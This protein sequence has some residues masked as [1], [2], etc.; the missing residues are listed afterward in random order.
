MVFVVLLDAWISLQRLSL[1]SIP[2]LTFLTSHPLERT[3]VHPGQPVPGETRRDPLESRRL[4]SPL[5]SHQIEVESSVLDHQGEHQGSSQPWLLETSSWI[6]S[7]D[8]VL[9]M[10]V[11]RSVESSDHGDVD[12]WSACSRSTKSCCPLQGRFALQSR[13]WAEVVDHGGVSQTVGPLGGRCSRS[14]HDG[15]SDCDDGP[16]H[17]VDQT[18]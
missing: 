18:D 8:A 9:L 1:R 14:H 10:N 11:D 7:F 2:I 16:H 4:A 15:A 17:S 5:E 12:R 3:K 13:V 6:S